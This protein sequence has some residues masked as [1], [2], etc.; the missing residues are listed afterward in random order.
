[1][2]P[3]ISNFG[4]RLNTSTLAFTDGTNISGNAAGVID[5][6]NAYL[7]TNNANSPIGPVDVTGQTTV[8]TTPTITG[9]VTLASGETLKVEVNGVL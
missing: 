9:T 3:S 5:A 8:N 4:L 2:S 7:V 1:M 6:L